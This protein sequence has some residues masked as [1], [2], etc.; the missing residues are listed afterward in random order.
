MNEQDKKSFDKW[1]DKNGTWNN[2]ID[3]ALWNDMEKLFNNW[4][5][6]KLRSEELEAKLAVA[7]ASLNSRP[8]VGSDIKPYYLFLTPGKDCYDIPEGCIRSVFNS[9]LILQEKEDSFKEW[10]YKIVG[11]TIQFSPEYM[12]LVDETPEREW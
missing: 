11:N 10:D 7:T 8:V 5:S 2:Y 4:Q 6:E 12:Q 3:E 9:G 1:Y